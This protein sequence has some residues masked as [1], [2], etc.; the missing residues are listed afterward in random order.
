VKGHKIT[1]WGRFCAALAVPLKMSFQEAENKGPDA[2]ESFRHEMARNG[3]I[4][5][6]VQIV[7]DTREGLHDSPLLPPFVDW[8][9]LLVFFGDKLWELFAGEFDL[10]S[11]SNPVR[12]AELGLLTSA[13]VFF[14]LS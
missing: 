7:R 14:I 12:P 9:S 3:G 10:K 13:Y 5:V 1:L 8:L 4:D 6:S 2:L 11:C